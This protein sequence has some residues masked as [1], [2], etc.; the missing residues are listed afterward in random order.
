MVGHIIQ[1]TEWNLFPDRTI[2][3]TYVQDSY[4]TL[5]RIARK[6]AFLLHIARLNGHQIEILHDQQD[7]ARNLQEKGH[8]S[9]N[10]DSCKIAI[11]RCP[12]TYVYTSIHIAWRIGETMYAAAIAIIYYF[13][14]YPFQEDVPPF[15]AYIPSVNVKE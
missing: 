1:R 6:G 5:A 4:K 12:K 14:G 9:C 13:Y 2:A 11:S 8:L 15:H 10:Q 7:H 3:C